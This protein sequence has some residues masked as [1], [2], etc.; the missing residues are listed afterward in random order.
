[1]NVTETASELV[2]LILQE[3]SLLD[4]ADAKRIIANRVSEAVEPFCSKRPLPNPDGMVPMT[5]AE[6]RRFGSEPVPFGAYR[7]ADWNTVPLD[8]LEW[9]ADTARSNWRNL[10]RYLHSDYVKRERRASE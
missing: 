4:D 9:Y 10:W 5:D 3:M 7:D 8:R 2:N 6:A 1:M